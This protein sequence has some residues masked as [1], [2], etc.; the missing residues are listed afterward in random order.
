M[1]GFKQSAVRE[2][3]WYRYKTIFFYCVDNGIFIGTYPIA[4]NKAIEE[5]ER[6]GLDIEGKVNIEDYLGV[7][8]EE[9][10]NGKIRLTYPQISDSIINDV[11]LPKNTVPRQTPALSTNILRRDATDPPFDEHF[12]YRA[13]MGKLNF[14]ENIARPYIAYAMHQCAHFSQDTRSSQGYS[15]INLVKY[16]KSTRTQGITRVPNRNKSFEFYANTD[17]YG[18]WHCPNVGDDP[19]TTNSRTG[20]AILYAGCTIIW[21]S[22]LLTHIALSMTEEEYIDLSQ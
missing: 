19:S 17:F 2:C 12:N 22:K 1:I 10:Y 3:V 20:Y 16:P 9:Q 18:K 11:H 8:I 13:V 6:A 14:L 15:I 21:R 7:N 5:I 4:I